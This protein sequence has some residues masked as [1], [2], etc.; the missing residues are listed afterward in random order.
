MAEH[1]KRG[2][3]RVAILRLEQFYP[4]PRTLLQQW[5]SAYTKAEEIVWAQEEPQNMG[6]WNFMTASGGPTRAYGIA[7]RRAG[8]QR[9]PGDRLVYDSSA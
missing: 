2:P 3:G 7:L 6:G 5:L 1:E 9:K 8:G 4:F